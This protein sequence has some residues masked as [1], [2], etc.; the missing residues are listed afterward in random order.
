MLGIHEVT[1]YIIVD[2]L[3]PCKALLATGEFIAL[4]HGDESLDVNPPQLLVPLQLLHWTVQ[5][6]HEVEDASVLLV[7]TILHL[8]K[9]NLHGLLNEGLVAQAL[10]KV[11][12]EPHGLDGMTGIQQTAIHAIHHLVVGAKV[13]Y[14]Q[15]KF[16]TIEYIHHLVDTGFYGLVEEILVEQRFYLKCHIAENHGQGKALQ[17]TS[18]GCCL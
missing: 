6:V 11:H 1:P 18:T 17:C 12:D 13:L 9:G 14:N 15:T 5:A 10:A 7:P 3:K 16:R 8:G 2:A 4:D